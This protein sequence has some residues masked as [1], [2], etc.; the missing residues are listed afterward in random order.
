MKR[1]ENGTLQPVAPIGRPPNLTPEKDEELL[2]W[3]KERSR[4]F[5]TQFM[6]LM[7]LRLGE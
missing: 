7:L 2:Q 6:L 4:S 3:I 1:F 5:L